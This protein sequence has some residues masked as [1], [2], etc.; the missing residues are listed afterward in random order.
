MLMKEYIRDSPI[1]PLFYNYYYFYP[2]FSVLE[3]LI[4]PIPKQVSW[5]RN[6]LFVNS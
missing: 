6:P 3:F 1:N 5:R 4:Y 2:V